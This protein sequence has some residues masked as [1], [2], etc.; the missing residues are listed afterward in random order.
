MIWVVS[1]GLMG[2]GQ[3]YTDSRKK[4]N[5]KKIKKNN[6]IKIKITSNLYEYILCIV[7]KFFFFKKIFVT[8][9]FKFNN[10]FIKFI[11]PIN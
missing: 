8:F 3:V 2:L 6:I 4:K 5:R 7:A 9:I 1:M 11:R 10:K